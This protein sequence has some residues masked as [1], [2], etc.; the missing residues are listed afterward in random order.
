MLNETKHLDEDLVK[1]VRSNLEPLAIS[2]AAADLACLGR[3]GAAWPRK[4]KT[5]WAGELRRLAREGL[6]AMHDGGR[7]YPPSPKPE[8]TQTKS[9]SKPK[10]TA[11]P[12]VIQGEL[13]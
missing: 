13:F 8:P 12:A 11:K 6:L 3:C 4:S 5:F 10:L 7:V 1:Y 2:E 9:T